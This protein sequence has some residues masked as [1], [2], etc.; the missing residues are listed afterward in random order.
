MEKS[1]K[2]H[3]TSRRS[4]LRG[5]ALWAGA[6]VAGL[7]P[8]RQASGKTIFLNDPFQLGVASGDAVADGFVIWTRIA[9]DPFDPQALPSEA[10]QVAW[11]VAADEGMKKIVA[12]GQVWAR[13]DMAH[14]VHVDVR[15]LEP[16]RPYFYRFHCDGVVSRTGRAMTLPTPRLPVERLRFAFASCSHLEQGYFSAYRDMAAQNPDFILHLGDYIYESSWGTAVRHHPGP[17]PTTLE[18]YRLHHAAYKLDPDLQAAHAHCPWF[19]TWD[20]HEVANDY[21]PN[22][23]QTTPD[24]AAFR[25]RKL[26]A[27]KAYYEHMPLR[28]AAAFTET[29]ML[30][31]QRVL[32]GDL[33]QFDITDGR[34]YRDPT[35]CQPPD[36]KSG[37]LL[38]VADCADYENPARTMLGKAQETWLR[39]GFARS[40][41]RWNVLA[42]SLMFSD[43]DQILGPGRGVYTDSWGGYPAARR[44]L[45]DVVKERKVGNVITLA[46]DIHSFFVSDVKDDPTNLQSATLMSEFVGSSVTAESY[47]AEVFRSLMPENPHIKFCDDTRRGYIMCDVT[48]D[49]WRADLRAA[50]NIRVR[51]P[52]FS[53]LKS[54]VVESGRPGP[55]SA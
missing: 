13:P 34:Q 48:K 1:M 2:S 29:E 11:E 41:T 25:R 17:E 4:L 31:Y 44:R 52:N 43:F 16:R 28:P 45:L 15:G 6:T 30:M 7:G 12:H 20:D 39:N 8:I 38:N 33:A 5:A 42:H 50:D 26:A 23:S 24:P 27:Y 19:F 36:W 9:P 47:N 22:E 18:A 51:Q 3:M 35:P 32:F 46:G 14:S 10:L 49:T 40:D 53:T 55:Q 37:R 54:F 21:S